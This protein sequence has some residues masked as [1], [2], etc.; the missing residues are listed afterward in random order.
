MTRLGR[1]VVVSHDALMK[2][3]DAQSTDAAPARAA[4]PPVVPTAAKDDLADYLCP[5]KTVRAMTDDDRQRYFDY[6]AA[7]T[8]L[9]QR[10]ALDVST[11]ALLPQTEKAL[12]NAGAHTIGAMADLYPYQLRQ[13]LNIGPHQLKAIQSRLRALNM[14]LTHACGYKLKVKHK[15]VPLWQRTESMSKSEKQR[16]KQMSRQHK[17]QCSLNE[18]ELGVRAA[19]LLN[20]AKLWTIGDLVSK[21]EAQMLAIPKMGKQSLNEIKCRLG[22]IGLQFAATPSTA[23]A[24][25]ARA[26]Y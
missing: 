13:I 7:H 22:E 2:W 21:T 18:I 23:A 10:R 17:L 4:K 14:S 3:I 8:D 15:T 20:D 26:D 24:H 12:K 5:P 9:T 1:R 25:S 11:L 6:I 16:W 19:G